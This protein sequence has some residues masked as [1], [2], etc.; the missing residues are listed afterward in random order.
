MNEHP[1]LSENERLAMRLAD[2]STSR[3]VTLDGKTGE[4]IMEEHNIKK[5][6]NQVDQYVEKLNEHAK[7]LEDYSKKIAENVEKIE[8][9]PI[10]N[11]VLVKEFEENP[12]QR[13][14][15]D[16]NSGLILDLGGQ[17]P[18]YKN[19]D[20]GQIE[21]EEAFIKVGVIQEV[22]PECRWCKPEDTIMYTK[23][24]AVPVPF[25][26]QGLILVNETRVLVTIN[27][28]LSERFEKIKKELKK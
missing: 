14:V 13:I 7:R 15:K 24:S 8:I 11:Y 26:K 5:F 28:G 20:N 9:M 21:E 4:E 27:E 12:F 3:I 19:T 25:Y 18:Q 2:E 17:R 16:T 1:I 6:N 23:P 10:G 22:G